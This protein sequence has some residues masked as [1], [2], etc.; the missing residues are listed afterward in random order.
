MVSASKRWLMLTITPILIHVPMTF[1]TGTFIIVANSLAVTNSVSFRILLSARSS[2]RSSSSRSRTCSRFSLRYLAPFVFLF[3]LFVRRAS[4]SFTCLATSSSLISVLTTSLTL[5]LRLRLLLCDACWLLPLLLLPLLPGLRRSLFCN[6]FAVALMSTR[7]APIRLRFFFSR[8]L[9]RSSLPFFFGRVDWLSVER[10]ICPTTFGALNSGVERNSNTPFFVSP[11][12]C[13]RS[14]F[15][16][17]AGF[18]GFSVALWASF[19]SLFGAEDVSFIGSVGLGSS[20]VTS[21]FTGSS[22]FA[23]VSLTGA[24]STSFGASLIAGFSSVGTS[25]G[26]STFFPSSGA[27]SALAGASRST[28]PL[29][30]ICGR[31]SSGTTVFT[32]SVARRSDFCAFFSFFSCWRPWLSSVALRRTSSSFWNSRRNKSYCSSDNLVLG[33]DSISWPFFAKN[34]TAVSLPML[35]SLRAL[36]NL[37]LMLRWWKGKNG[38]FVIIAQT[39][40]SIYGVLRLR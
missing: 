18:F 28:C 29:I 15:V 34:S 39:L 16:G 35:N 5:R 33:F 26:F 9:R 22:G 7:C 8:S 2:R 25:T 21:T 20:C 24:L 14:S 32:S 17:L 40:R 1:V 37:M 3:D 38:L 13:S 23:D 31:K 12:C 30:L 27:G 19:T 10:S 6:W 36:F 4:V 11:I